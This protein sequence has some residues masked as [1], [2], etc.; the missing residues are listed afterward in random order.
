[1]NGT[2][3][4]FGG[5]RVLYIQKRIGSLQRALQ[6]FCHINLT[7]VATLAPIEDTFEVGELFWQSKL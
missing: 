6:I 3:V 7:I 2:L 4:I 5:L 1:M